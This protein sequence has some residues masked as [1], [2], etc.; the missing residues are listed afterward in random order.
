MNQS[1]LTMWNKQTKTLF[2]FTKDPPL[3]PIHIDDQC[4]LMWCP[5]FLT[6]AESTQLYQ[7]LLSSL[8]FERSV[9]TLA[10]KLIAVPRLQAW[11]ADTDVVVDGLYQKQTQHEWTDIVKRI[12]L[13][14]E[15]QLGCTFM[16]CLVNLYRDGNDHIAFHSD[17]EVRGTVA[18]LSVGVARKFV[19]QHYSAFGLDKTKAGGPLSTPEQ[20][21]YEFSLSNGSMIAMLDGTQLY[22]KHKVPEEKAIK[23]KRINLTF[24]T[25]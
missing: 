21:K 4:S 3:Q 20:T 10:G 2:E 7:H 5:H 1:L 8:D 9:I 19:L 6:D 23:D 24:R 22:W 15:K 12:K 17:N 18:S 16:Y 25:L 13:Q 11:F 14:L